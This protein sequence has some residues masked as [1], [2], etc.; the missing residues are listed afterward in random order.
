MAYDARWGET[1]RTFAE[2]DARSDKRL[3]VNEH[4]LLPTPDEAVA[5]I[6]SGAFGDGCEDGTYTIFA[7]HRMC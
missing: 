2:T 5:A 7:V 4:C 3:P 1:E 6:D